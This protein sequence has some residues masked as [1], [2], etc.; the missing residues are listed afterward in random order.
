MNV[1]LKLPTA[2][3]TLTQILPVIRNIEN[4]IVESASEEIQASGAAISCRAGCGA[5][6]RQMVPLS[7]FEAEALTAWLATLPEAEMIPIRERFHRTLSTLR[8]AGVLDT[9]L[10][11]S[12]M[13]DEQRTAKL[14]EDYFRAGVPC[15]FLI[16][17]SCSIHPIRPLNCR[18]YLVTSPP[19]LCNDPW[20]NPVS[21]VNLPLR[22]SRALFAFGQQV[23]R[24]PCGWI[25]LVFLL[26][27]GE[28][29][30]TPGESVA[31][32]GI[33]VFRKFLDQVSAV[34]FA[35]PADPQPAE[36]S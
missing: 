19:E 14:A 8:D 18:E 24:G 4:A 17:E 10:E 5:C 29:G 3:T 31:G 11:G 23:E 33:E 6:C 16:D 13:L 21:G 1:T 36:P 34:S 32:S 15:P 9:I 20:A 27:W 25:P 22:L 7:I 12:W 30:A 2:R 28:S 26:A 35:K